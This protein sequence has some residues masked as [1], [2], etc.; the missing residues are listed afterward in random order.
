MIERPFFEWDWVVRNL[1]VIWERLG[2]H[3]WLTVLAVAIGLAISLP[4]GVLAHRLRRLY[5]AVAG[6]AGVLFATGALEPFRMTLFIIQTFAVTV[7]ALAS[8][9]NLAA[10]R[11]AEVE[12]QNA[13]RVLDATG[14]GLYGVDPSGRISFINPVLCELLGRD[15]A[16]LEGQDQHH[17]LGHRLSTGAAVD[18]ADCAICATVDSDVPL[19]RGEAVV[20]GAD[21]AALPV[22]YVARPLRD[23]G[24]RE[25]TVVTLRDLRE[26]HALEA[27]LREQALCDPL[28]GLANRALLADH[29]RLGLA[30]LERGNRRLGVLFCDLNRFKVLND[31][32]GHTAGDEV[33]RVVAARLQ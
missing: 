21:G 12:R 26:R 6:F 25:G 19:L 31:S 17:A 16:T 5:P 3:V 1:D 13:E 27:R 15:R 24:R 29:V 2:E 10:W 9:A 22:E 23:R 18:P 33:L 30:G 20:Q 4:L 11:L 7:V 14:D 28:T 32:L 8:L